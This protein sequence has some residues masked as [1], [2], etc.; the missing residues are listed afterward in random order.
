MST[1]NNASVSTLPVCAHG[2]RGSRRLVGALCMQSGL[3]STQ[4]QLGL[5]GRNAGVSGNSRGA[6]QAPFFL[7]R[8]ADTTALWVGVVGGTLGE[9]AVAEAAAA[10]ASGA[11]GGLAAVD[12]Q[13]RAAAVGR[14]PAVAAQVRVAGRADGTAAGADRTAAGASIIA[15]GTDWTATGTGI[16]A[17][18]AG[19]GAAR[20]DWTATRA[21]V[22]DAGAGSIGCGTGGCSCVAC[23]RRRRGR[24]HALK[25]G[26]CKAWFPAPPD[27]LLR[28]CPLQPH[29]TPSLRRHCSWRSC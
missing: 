15:A 25:Q 6:E 3:I 16:T 20:A 4:L 26:A 23:H 21:G 18:G 10:A 27:A 19:I 2:A 9:P 12:V 17:A 11:D 24:I 8:L 5:S 7:S 22:A 29:C 13:A 1:S 14:V 28:H